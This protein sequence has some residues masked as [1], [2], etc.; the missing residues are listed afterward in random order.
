MVVLAVS[1]PARAQ[2]EATLSEAKRHFDE[3]QVL[4]LAGRFAEAA[5]E[6]EQAFA[7]KPYA[8]FLFN[9]AVCHEKSGDLE[10]ALDRYARYVVSDPNAAERPDIEKRIDALREQLKAQSALP[11]ATG[12]AAPAPVLP[13]VETRGLVV[14]ESKPSEAAVYIDARGASPAGATPFSTTLDGKH[15]IIVEAKGYATERKEI[16]P[17]PNQM[18][19]LYIALSKEHYLGWIEIVAPNVPGADVYFDS[20]DSGVAGKTPFMGNLRPGKHKVWVAREGFA[21]FESELDIQ[22]GGTH[23]LDAVLEPIRYGYV[24]VL[25]RTTRGATVLVDERPVDCRGQYPCRVELPPGSYRIEVASDGQ[26]SYVETVNVVRAQ[27][28][29]M[30]VQLQ[31]APSRVSAYVSLGVAAAFLGTGTY[32]GLQS[33]GDRASL[34]DDNADPA[35]LASDD[36]PRIRR[37]KIYA[38]VADGLFAVGGVAG[39]L[40]VYYLLRDEGP[41]SIGEHETLPL[42][43][44]PYASPDSG[45]LVARTSF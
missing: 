26:K 15:T 37:G 12:P 27:E 36:D 31:P 19:Y 10:K 21:L 32:F 17:S 41:P 25:G 38:L 6:F 4:Y 40:G 29:K 13:A 35:A 34:G 42:A 16:A 14:V 18:T 30:R 43:L 22:P 1:L 11:G 3:G 33:R 23:H 2:D 45:G 28:T 8:A 24:K 39:I 5:V 9:E 44:A 20:R 7:K